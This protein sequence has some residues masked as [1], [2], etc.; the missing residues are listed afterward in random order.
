MLGHL[1]LYRAYAMD[2]WTSIGCDGC[3]TSN[4]ACCGIISYIGH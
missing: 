3:G 4:V 2:I 1:T